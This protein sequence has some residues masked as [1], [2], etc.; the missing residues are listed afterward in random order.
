MDNFQ[1]MFHFL[2]Y[3]GLNIAI[4]LS[5]LIDFIVLFPAMTEFFL[6]FIWTLVLIITSVTIHNSII[7]LPEREQWT[8][9]FYIPFYTLIYLPI[10]LLC[11][12]GGIVIGVI[13]RIKHRPELD[14]KHW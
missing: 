5:I 1:A 7:M 8:D 4:L 6:S 10:V 14:F 12:V 2:P 3:V 9:V 11:Y 13:D